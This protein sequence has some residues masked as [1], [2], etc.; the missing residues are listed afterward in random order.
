MA[1]EQMW[2]FHCNDGFDVVGPDKREVMNAARVHLETKH[3]Q[4]PTD[5]EVESSIQQV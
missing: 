5:Q 3:D 1:E 2:K 4:H